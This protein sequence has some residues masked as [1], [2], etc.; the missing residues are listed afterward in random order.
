M[1]KYTI[2]APL[3]ALALTGCTSVTNVTPAADTTPTTPPAQNQMP[4]GMSMEPQT[5]PL[6]T[7]EQKAQ[8][9][10]GVT[11]HT[12]KTLTFNITGGSFYFAP[13]VLHAKKG[14][15]IKIIFTNAGGMHN[16]VLDEFNVAIDPIQTGATSTVEFVASK[17]GTFEFYCSVGQHRK[18]GQK[19][20]LIVE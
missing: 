3:M 6:L 15:T 4:A 19:G 14:D 20:T 1:K 13:N 12:P 11:A 7:V 10:V 8:L 17:T 5:P 18:M 9:E 2:I 16:F